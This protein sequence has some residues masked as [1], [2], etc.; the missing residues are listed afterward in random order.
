[1]GQIGS[2]EACFGIAPALGELRV[3]QRSVINARMAVMI[4]EAEAALAKVQGELQA[5][6]RWSEDFGRF[7]EDGAQAALLFIGSGID[8]PQLHNP[9]YDFPDALVPVVS[10]LWIALVAEI[11]EA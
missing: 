2:G 3:T 11:L 8:Q 5:P 6:M 4:S 9:D 1:M 10:E 7:G